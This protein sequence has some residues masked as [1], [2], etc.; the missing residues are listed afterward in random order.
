M[1]FPPRIVACPVCGQR[2]DADSDVLLFLVLGVLL[3][4]LLTLVLCR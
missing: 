1:K 2:F 4:I 3:G